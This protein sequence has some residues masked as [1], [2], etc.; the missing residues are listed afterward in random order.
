MAI[1]QNKKEVKE[2]E[3]ADDEI[4]TCLKNNPYIK[5]NQIVVSEGF[6]K[7]RPYKKRVLATNPITIE[8]FEQTG[9]KVKEFYHLTD[10]QNTDDYPSGVYTIVR[11]SKGVVKT[12]DVTN[13]EISTRPFIV[14]CLPTVEGLAQWQIVELNDLRNTTRLLAYRFLRGVKQNREIKEIES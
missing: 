4:P 1:I 10:E 12:F 5:R 3:I 9:V 6:A 2:K 11:N 7:R 14:H 13:K 8:L